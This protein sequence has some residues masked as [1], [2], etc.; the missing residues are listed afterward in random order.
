MAIPGVDAE[1]IRQ[2]LE[3]FDRNLRTSTEW[4]SWEDNKAQAWVLVVGERR[5]PPK[6]IISIAT[7]IPVSSFSGGTET[8]DY[9][10]ERGFTVTRLRETSLSETLRLILQRYKPARQQLAFGGHHEIKEL[11]T[12]A[13][14][15]L[16]TSNPVTKHPHVHVVT[17]YG[18][19][20]WATI[21][22]ISFLDERETRTTQSGTYVVYLFKEDGQGCYLKL[23]QGVTA[24]EK[25]HGAKAPEILGAKASKIRARCG[26]LSEVGFDLSGKTSL[27]TT[28]KL[29]KLYEASTIASKYYAADTMPSDDVL[30]A[31]LEH[32]LSAYDNYVEET[33][34]A[35]ASALIDERPLALI[36]SFQSTVTD[37]ERI[38][39]FINT[40]GGWSSW[41]S[42]PIKEEA[43]QRLQTPFSLFLYAGKQ[44]VI[45]RL[46]VDEFVTERGSDG[47]ISPWPEQT[48]EEWRGV[49]RLGAKQSE[50]CKTWFKVGEIE[51]FA[52]P[53]SVNDFEV[54]VGL[55]TPENLLNQNSFGYVI[56]MES[57]VPSALSSLNSPEP[58]LAKSR[59]APLPLKWLEETTGL[60][61]DTLTAM[62]DAI[63][64]TSPQIILAGPPGTSKTWVARQLAL[65][66]TR[67]RPDQI[68]FVQFHQSYSYESFIEG[69]RPVTKDNAVGF[70][71]KPGVVLDVVEG[72]RRADAVDSSEDEYV[73]VIDEANRANLPRVLGELMF[74]FEYRG[75]VAHLQYSGQFSLPKNLRFIATMNTADRSIRAID[76]ALRRRFDVFELGPDANI[77]DLYHLK[78]GDLQVPDLVD[79]FLALNE[80]LV[81][82]LDRHHTIG[83]AFFMQPQMTVSK[84]KG[85]WSRKVFPLIEE[86][87]FDQPELAAEFTCERFW[88]SVDGA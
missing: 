45:A 59:P 67:N 35:D 5:Y 84:L 14:K 46:R 78:N 27:A 61:Q 49:R 32:L 69:L 68:R 66:L 20:N 3:E 85:I 65:F 2:A 81:K 42:F 28:Q 83:H 1:S 87:F 51:I 21:P 30:L 8:N 82:A 40:R 50:I 70:E 13:R 48:F 18:K 47:Q 16:T 41:W 86:F 75:E 57:E 39:E 88:P 36:G 63:T 25:N 64:G 24:A 44:R 4:S 23:G 22:W 17:S 38:S 54:A 31:D 60:S 53:I 34:G 62:V 43:K 55:S 19:G 10:A 73:I 12:Q 58:K 9:F 79:G 11:F 74:L 29:G 6:K 77:L 56:E 15:F 80:A 52:T 37:L 7:G 26:H 72:M 76:I 33:K 71:L